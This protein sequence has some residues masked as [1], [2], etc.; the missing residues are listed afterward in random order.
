MLSWQTQ[1]S[2]PGVIAK[3]YGM[4]FMEIETDSISDL[5]MKKMVLDF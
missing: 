5:F 2:L 1:L 3:H 4:Q